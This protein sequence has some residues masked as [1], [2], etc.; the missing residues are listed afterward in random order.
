ME[1]EQ[2]DQST[3][4]RSRR[5]FYKIL[6]IVLGCL[7]LLVVA[8]YATVEA[9]S[10]SSFCGSCHNMKPE[11]ETWKASSHSQIACKE[12]HI[13]E[14]VVN[15][16][17]AKLNG[18]KQVVDYT[19]NNYEAPIAMKVGKEIP[20][21]T[22]E[23]CHDMKTRN[24]TTEDDIIIPH[25]K[26]LAKNIKCVTCHYDVVHG[27]VSDRGV[28]Y[29]SDYDKWNDALG[30]QMMSDVKFTQPK[31]EDCIKCH[32]AR[33]VSTACKTC[34]ST[35]MKP[36]SHNDPNFMKGEHG[37]LA[38]KDIKKCNSCHQYMSDTPI[39]DMKTKSASDQ[40][41]NTGK[42]KEGTISVQ[43]YAKENTFC[44]KCHSKKPASH[45]S[46]WINAHGS[47]AN[48]N[49][50]ECLT[51]HSDKSATTSNSITSNG[52][53][54]NSIPTVTAGA[55]P[56]CT[57]CHPAIHAGKDYKSHHP[58]DLTGVTKPSATCYTCHAKSTCITCHKED[59]VTETQATSDLDNF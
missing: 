8:G 35:G 27:D 54:S 38:E 31:M 16:A 57:S 22:C 15:Y 19:S 9:T 12:C 50:Q 37:Q 59:G 4:N 40:F 55:A 30:K 43:D 5:N 10:S 45:D 20:N 48:T 47:A 58:I 23:K 26:H 13:Q 2:K 17:K 34:H 14:G 28:T 32:E 44:S 46:K 11:A 56:A 18:L 3:I 24:V 51:C 21:E 42:A 49:K 53:V 29:K 25:D 1:D 41:L 52:L 39:K 7:V 33:K 6:T 36:K